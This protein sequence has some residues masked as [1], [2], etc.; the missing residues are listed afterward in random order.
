MTREEFK[1][2]KIGDVCSLRQGYSKG[3]RGTVVYKDEVEDIGYVLLKA[4]DEFSVQGVASNRFFRL[5]S[6]RDVI[7]ERE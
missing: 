2:L 5:T 3:M 1:N 6:F 4:L 7:V